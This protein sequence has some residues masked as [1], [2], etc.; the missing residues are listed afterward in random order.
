MSALKDG[1]L[2]TPRG[3]H[4]RAVT[5]SPPPDVWKPVLLP[6]DEVV[7][8]VVVVVAVVLSSKTSQSVCRQSS[9]MAKTAKD[10]SR[11]LVASR[12]W[13]GVAANSERIHGTIHCKSIVTSQPAQLFVL[14]IN[15]VSGQQQSLC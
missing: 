11:C 10:P 15:R 7:S 4:A 8:Q 3:H 5:L 14:A 6:T 9:A 2:T 13:V 1:I 12:H